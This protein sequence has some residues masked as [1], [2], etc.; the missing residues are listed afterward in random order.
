MD[1]TDYCCSI[2]SVTLL[3]IERPRNHSSQIAALGPNDKPLSLSLPV[4]DPKWRFFWRMGPPPK[5]TKFPL[6]NMDAVI[7]SEIPEWSEVM[8]T[9]GN[10]MLDTL[11]TVS[12]MIALGFDLP[13]DTF[14]KKLFCGPHLLAPTGSDYSLYNKE[15][16]VLAGFHYDLNFLTIHGKSRYPGLYIWT[17]EGKKMAVAVPEGCLL[18][19]V[20]SCD[21]LSFKFSS[22]QG[23][24]KRNLS[25]LFFR[26]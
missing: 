16:T 6:L 2:K 25:L 20:T 3:L 26:L 19:Q 21:K 10:K 4:H 12:E 8:D 18:V 23:W 11:N 17:K 14:S 15:G 1:L 13:V 7:P 5:K 9:W 24:K 22:R